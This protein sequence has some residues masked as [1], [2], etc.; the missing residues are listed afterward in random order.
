VDLEP[1]YDSD[2]Q[3]EGSP[4]SSQ[5]PSGE[6]PLEPTPPPAEPVAPDPVASEPDAVTA[7]VP[8]EPDPVAPAVPESSSAPQA[9]TTPPPPEPG[10]VEP[11]QPTAGL[12]SAQ[13]VGTSEI[14]AGP[15]PNAPLVAWAA[16]D[17]Q[18]AF[19][20]A[21]GLVIAGTFT[22]L[23]AY[24]ADLL[25]LGSIGLAVNGALGLFDTGR[26]ATTAV[27][28]AGVL[29]G[30]DFL[31]FVGLWTS[32]FQATLGM[33]MLRLRILGAAT[34]GT[35]SVNDGVLRWLALSGA[36]GIL[37]LVPGLS[38]FLGLLSLI[39]L[40]VLLGTTA[41]NPLHQGLHDR[42]AR[43]VVVQPAPGGSGAAF[44]TCLILVVF[45]F[46]LLPILALFLAGDQVAHL[47]SQIGESI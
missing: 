45:V 25:L 22:R 9:P 6:P 14:Q 42:W 37:T 39:W 29:V 10:P 2:V 36:V 28:V 24:A 11:P 12:I 38:G 13:P 30:V 35:L 34:A 23:V 46:I 15:P 31:Y 7:R 44:A 26:D 27:I 47:L 41:L 33:R 17:D 18:A 5:T 40:V 4:M 1:D 21:E 19:P 43:S 8:L 20:V 16:P 32:G 3:H